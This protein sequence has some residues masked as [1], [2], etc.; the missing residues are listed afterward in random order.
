MLKSKT[1]LFSSL[2]CLG[3][4]ACKK[5][6]EKGLDCD[7]EPT[8]LSQV[9]RQYKNDWHY[10][11]GNVTISDQN[12]SLLYIEA[13]T[14]STADTTVKILKD[15]TVHKTQTIEKFK[16]QGCGEFY[17]AIGDSIT[18]N[19]DGED[20]YIDIKQMHFDLLNN[21][22]ETV[23]YQYETNILDN[24]TINLDAKDNVV[25]GTKTYNNLVQINISAGGSTRSI[26]FT[27]SRIIEYGMG[28]RYFINY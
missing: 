28:K 6:E 12:D 18:F 26:L 13:L 17:K 10:Y 8:N 9:E 14:D 27:K 11:L 3:L 16:S 5:D 25:R 19:L 1:I 24:A 23:E 22:N 21:G 7:P 2:V 15:F 20:F 4:I